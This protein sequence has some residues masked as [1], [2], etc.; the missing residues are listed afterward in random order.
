MTNP[1]DV[2]VKLSAEGV[3]E[4][5]A[6]F[7]RVQD[8]AEMSGKGVSKISTAMGSVKNVFAGLGAAKVANEFVALAKRSM[9]LADSLGKLSQKSGVSVETLSTLSFAARTADVEQ[10]GLAASLIKFARSMDDYDRGVKL[11]RDAVRGLFGDAKALMGLKQDERFLRIAAALGKLEPGAKRTGTAMQFFGKSGAELLP[12]IDDLADGGFEKLRDK[13]AKLGLVIDTD[14]ARAAQQANDAMTDLRSA[15]EGMA[16]QFTAGFAPAVLQAANSLTR[17]VADDGVNGFKQLGEIAGEVLKWI[18]AG[19]HTAAM[20]ITNTLMGLWANARRTLALLDDWVHLRFKGSVERY[21][22]GL[23][24]DTRAIMDTAL[25][26]YRKALAELNRVQVPELPGERRDD[27]ASEDLLAKQEEERQTKERERRLE[28]ERKAA[29]ELA[30]VRREAALRVGREELKAQ[31]T[32]DEER[33][34]AGLLTLR[35]YYEARIA[36]AQQQAELEATALYA[37]LVEL[38]TTPLGKDELPDERRAQILKAAADFQ[39]ALLKG[40]T[41]INALKAGEAKE[42]TDLQK[43]VMDFEAKY[44]ESQEGRFAAARAAIDEEA[45]ELDELL[46]KMGIADAE[47]ERRV[48]EFRESG[49]RPIE[50]EEQ[51]YDF[52]E[53][54]AQASAALDELERQRRRIDLQVMS[55]QMFAYEGEQAIM[56]LERERLPLLQQI[57]NAMRASAITPEQIQTAEQF[58]LQIDELATSSDRAAQ[59]MGD[60]KLSVEGAMTSDVTNWLTS[61]IEQAESW[62]DAF[63]SAALSVVQSLRQIA[64]QMLATLMIQ[65]LLGALGG[66][67]GGGA[68]GGGGGIQLARGGLVTGPGTST[69]DSIPARLSNWEYVVRAEV[70][71][72]P[73]MLE[74][75]NELNF[76]TPKIRPLHRYR[77]AEG[78]LVDA[79]AASPGSSI[80]A[81]LTVDLND[82]LVLKRLEASPEFH[83][84]VVRTIG[85]N[86]KGIS[87]ILGG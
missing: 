14:L 70:V 13:A 69:S 86:R 73:G 20:L 71:K 48:A 32:A 37:R 78:G 24:D 74:Y 47:R 28:R 57:A 51:Q 59:A 39:T 11:T 87:R 72:R 33:Y 25:S 81:G 84:V 3:A 15:T 82:A 19:F 6:A 36:L 76:G 40:Q 30:G 85:N 2:R 54:Q 34:D 7:K 65:K 75:L 5:V 56:D 68:P 64:S 23:T 44:R 8:E 4:V 52:D 79:Q 10:Q 67:F 53:M 43:Q 31:E 63:R 83:R 27:S 61:G 26:N 21:L 50:A 77:F 55:G 66:A 22:I 45:K 18:T 16:T 60:F 17:A 35:Q 80:S 62:G 12:L 38:Q 29:L 41:E 1:P 42:T 49:Y 9:D 58:Q 46:R